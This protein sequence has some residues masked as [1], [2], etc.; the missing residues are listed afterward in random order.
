MQASTLTHFSSLIARNAGNFSFLVL[1]RMHFKSGLW[2]ACMIIT[3]PS[4]TQSFTQVFEE[5]GYSFLVLNVSHWAFIC[6][7][8]YIAV[9]NIALCFYLFIT[10]TLFSWRGVLPCTQSSSHLF[11][12][13]NRKKRLAQKCESLEFIYISNSSVGLAVCP[14]TL[15]PCHFLR[16]ELSKI[17]KLYIMICSI[18]LYYMTIPTFGDHVLISR[19]QTHQKS[20]CKFNCALFIESSLNMM[21]WTLLKTGLYFGEKF[22]EVCNFAW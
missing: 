20:E 7:L 8:F 18:W 15:K 21:C 2:H 10:C 22:K 14:Q 19:S 11:L 12:Y 6:S 1:F 3:D 5:N 4:F 9:M 13:K 16:C 17:F